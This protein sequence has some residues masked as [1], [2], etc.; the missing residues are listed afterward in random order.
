[1]KIEPIT[2]IDTPNTN[3]ERICAK[4]YDI[5]RQAVLQDTVWSFAI[6]R[7]DLAADSETP[8][9]GWDYQSDDFPN[10]FLKLIGVY[11]ESGVLYLNVNN[12]SYEIE[13][14]KILTD[15]TAPYYIRYIADITDVNK[16][17][18]LFVMNFILT[19]PLLIYVFSVT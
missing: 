7:V 18:R 4:Y 16:F 14:N 8:D 11:N 12:T 1:M 17:D 3:E 15:L 2:N 10:D 19:S 6:K 9:F 5:T 13:G